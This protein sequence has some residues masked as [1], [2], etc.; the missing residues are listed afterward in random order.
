MTAAKHIMAADGHRFEIARADPV[1]APKGGV[2]VL[3]A[4]YGLTSHI[5]DVCDRWA[6]SGYTAVAPA[7][8]DRVGPGI[9]CGYDKSGAA[10]GRDTYAKLGEAEILADVAACIREVSPCGPVII[11]GFCTGGSFAWVASAKLDGIAAQVNWY[12]SHV[13]S[14]HLDVNPR[15]PTIIHYGDSDHI[16]PLADV[17]RIAPAHPHVEVQIYPKAGHAFLN[18]EQDS[19]DAAAAEASWQRSLEFLERTLPRR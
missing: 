17:H 19:H 12:G 10:Q 16:V 14:R 7:L 5:K 9:V 1:G 8:Y 13:A 4:I 15:V 3:H 6:S 2:I 18:P 11:S